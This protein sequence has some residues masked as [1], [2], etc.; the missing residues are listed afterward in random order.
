M[1][2]G[3]LGKDSGGFGLL[4]LIIVIVL[5]IWFVVGLY[6][7]EQVEEVVVLC[8]GKYYDIVNVGLYWNFWGIDI[9]YKVDV[10]QCEMMLVWVIMLIED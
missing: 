6:W 1:M 10:N 9:V 8:F 5:V 4:G 3:G 7:V 2:G